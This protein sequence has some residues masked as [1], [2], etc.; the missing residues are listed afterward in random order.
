MLRGRV[1]LVRT[2]VEG[3]LWER[4]SPA[5]M[6]N[7]GSRR[8]AKRTRTPSAAHTPGAGAGRFVFNPM[9]HHRGQLTVSLRLCDVPLPETYGP[10]ADNAR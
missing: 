8:L 7:A 3:L 4:Y 10:T 2:R 1:V 9:I 5:E 6:A